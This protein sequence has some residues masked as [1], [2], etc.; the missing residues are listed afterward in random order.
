MLLRESL[1]IPQLSAKEARLAATRAVLASIMVITSGS[2]KRATD[3]DQTDR[4][5]PLRISS[6]LTETPKICSEDHKSLHECNDEEIWQQT[7]HVDGI[8]TQFIRDAMHKEVRVHI[9]DDIFV[10]EPDD[11]QG[12]HIDPYDVIGAIA[13]KGEHVYLETNAQHP[14]RSLVTDVRVE[15]DTVEQI[16]RKLRETDKEVSTF[17]V[18]C[19]VRGPAVMAKNVARQMWGILSGETS[20][21]TIWFKSAAPVTF[22]KLQHHDADEKALAQNR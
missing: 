15:T 7:L 20:R 18:A 3:T 22:R 11:E 14:A 6:P 4:N 5:A 16:V 10:C 21:S 19:E 9:G 8:D 13:P 2:A 17:R 1:G 12:L